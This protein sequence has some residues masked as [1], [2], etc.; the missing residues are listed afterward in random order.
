VEPGVLRTHAN[1]WPVLRRPHKHVFA[2]LGNRLKTTLP[3]S[4]TL[5]KGGPNSFFGVSV[6]YGMSSD[7]VGDTAPPLA[8]V[9]KALYDEEKR[10]VLAEPQATP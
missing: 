9:L 4:C 8:D 10:L 1:A 2:A 5:S 7:P 6:L 3:P